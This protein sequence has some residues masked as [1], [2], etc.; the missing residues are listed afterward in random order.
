MRD[1]N[2]TIAHIERTM[3]RGLDAPVPRP[4]SPKPQRSPTAWRAPDARPSIIKET[5][6]VNVQAP[7]TTTPTPRDASQLTARNVKLTVPLDSAQVMQLAVRDGQAR[8]T[9]T[10]KF[11]HGALKID[12]ATKSV[13]KAQKMIAESGADNVFVMLQGKLGKGEILDCGL[14]AQVKAAPK[15]ANVEEGKG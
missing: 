5:A 13:R 11:E 8:V 2:K 4:S 10:I 6:Q 7:T 15:N 1:L 12:I 3:T 14:V 9:F